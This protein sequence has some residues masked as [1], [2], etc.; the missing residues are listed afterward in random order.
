MKGF[1]NNEHVRE[2]TFTISLW[3]KLDI[4]WHAAT[5]QVTRWTP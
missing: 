3:H 5:R 2:N 1:V 4:I